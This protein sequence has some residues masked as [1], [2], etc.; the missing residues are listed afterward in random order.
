MVDQIPDKSSVGFKRLEFGSEEIRSVCDDASMEGLK[1]GRK[2]LRLV[3]HGGVCDSWKLL[4][5]KSELYFSE[6]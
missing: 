4:G 6:V 5:S 2:G 1:K 3:L